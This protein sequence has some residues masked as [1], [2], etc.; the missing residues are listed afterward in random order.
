VLLHDADFSDLAA[1]TFWLEAQQP[2]ST[3]TMRTVARRNWANV[4]IAFYLANVDLEP[5]ALVDNVTLKLAPGASVPGTSCVADSSG[6]LDSTVEGGADGGVP[7]PTV[8]TSPVRSGRGVPIAQDQESVRGGTVNLDAGWTSVGPGA[9]ADLEW[10]GRV[11]N[12]MISDGETSQLNGTRPIDLRGSTGGARLQFSSWRS[13]DSGSATVQ[14]SVDGVSWTTI[15]DVSASNDWTTYELNLDG[16][17]GQLVF[18]RFVHTADATG[19]TNHW[20]LMNIRLI[21]GLIHP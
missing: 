2:R 19:D 14:V 11:W 20:R 1:C 10:R 16:F 21:A 5:F 18:V 9:G 3:Y 17:A 13:A 12:S 8:Q 15:D 6:L 4:T 7:T